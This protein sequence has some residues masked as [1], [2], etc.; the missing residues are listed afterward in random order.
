MPDCRQH[1]Q[2][3]LVTT[4][5]RR[6]DMSGKVRS[7]VVFC[8]VVALCLF[9]P[10][11]VS[12]EDVV[13]IAPVSVSASTYYA[14]GYA[15]QWMIDGSGLTG[16]GRMATH[17]NANAQS[18][19]WHSQTGIVVSDQ[20][21]EFDLGAEYRVTNALVW[22]M[23]QLNLT[24]RGI[25]NFTI[26]VAASD[27]TFSTLS[28]GNTLTQATAAANTPVQV[29]PLAAGGVRY[30]RFEIE[31]NWGAGGIVGLS[32][33]RFEVAPP[34]PSTDI[35]FAPVGVS[36]S[37]YHAVEYGPQWLIDGSGLNGS[38]R[39]AT[40]T[41]L[42]ARYL[43]WHSLVGAVVSEQWVEF[44]LG[45]PYDLSNALVWQLAQSNNVNRG[46]SIFSVSVAGVDHTFSTVLT[47]NLLSKASTQPSA[48]VQVLPLVGKNI[49]YV[50]FD[51]H[52]NWGG[53]AS[54]S[55]KCVSRLLRR[56]PTPSC[57]SRSPT[58]SA[59]SIPLIPRR[60]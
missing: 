34:E 24:N 15:P 9:M 39:L 35:V 11:L 41:N 16:I 32:E 2:D 48:P 21:L 25:R 59:A 5:T 29:V 17:T 40:H 31:S 27:H 13:V 14:I 10:C 36:A 30:V 23:A 3:T 38:G 20:W 54:A 55:A 43:F 26:R 19:F 22:Q 42:N 60:T 33:V 45:V 4:G 49:R 37:S 58:P 51:I 57:V 18:L 7:S 46:V 6:K 12:A 1:W 28:T 44:D 50:R 56:R 47:S 52:S 53:I 8:G